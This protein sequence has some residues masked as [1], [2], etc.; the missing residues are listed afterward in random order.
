MY[1]AGSET[2]FSAGVV[3]IVDNV[4]TEAFVPI[5]IPLLESVLPD[6]VK[7][8]ITTT[9][10]LTFTNAI[11]FD[12]SFTAQIQHTDAWADFFE[13]KYIDPS[14][15]YFLPDG[16]SVYSYTPGRLYVIPPPGKHDTVKTSINPRYGAWDVLPSST[17]LSLYVDGVEYSGTYAPPPPIASVVIDQPALARSSTEYVIRAT[18]AA[19]AIARPELS[20]RIDVAQLPWSSAWCSVEG[21]HV[22]VVD[23]TAP[24]D[25]L[26]FPIPMEWSRHAHTGMLP[27]PLPHVTVVCAFTLTNDRAIYSPAAPAFE[28]WVHDGEREVARGQARLQ[29]LSDAVTAVRIGLD[30]EHSALKG[31]KLT[32]MY[33]SVFGVLT[34]HYSGEISADQLVLASQTHPDRGHTVLTYEITSQRA[35][36]VTVDDIKALADEFISA[37][38]SL[39]YTVADNARDSV[40]SRLVDASC[41]FECGSGCTLCTDGASCEWDPDCSG[42]ECKDGICHTPIPPPVDL[43]WLWASI[44]GLV[45]VVC[46]V[47]LYRVGCPALQA[48]IRKRAE[49]SLLNDMDDF[50]DF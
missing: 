48:R 19:P 22:G 30:I 8:S 24:E 23:Y 32:A 33:N 50:N 46:I 15:P 18:F 45:F 1:S 41:A 5:K 25:S 10:D 3:N 39:G 40:S 9:S 47:L 12:N 21:L 34:R 38:R 42:G 27:L 29:T 6:I 43:T 31:E 16:S 20:M 4:V 13:T 44:A 2:H 36:V 26:I 11:T 17:H 14:A 35:A 37:A 49:E 28:V 7:T